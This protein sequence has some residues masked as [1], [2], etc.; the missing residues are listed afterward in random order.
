M[1]TVAVA[2][3][4]WKINSFILRALIVAAVAYGTAYTAYWSEVWF[5]ATDDQ[6][7]SWAPLVINWCFAA[8]LI[9]GGLALVITTLLRRK[10]EAKRS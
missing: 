6:F 3:A 2:V 7:S 8:G 9:C 10:S 1:V 5:G 4:T